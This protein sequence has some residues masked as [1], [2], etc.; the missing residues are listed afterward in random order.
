LGHN[1]F[2]IL[3]NYTFTVAVD[4]QLS[5]VLPSLEERGASTWGYTREEDLRHI[6]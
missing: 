1:E 6:D 3:K 2:P 5:C 4:E